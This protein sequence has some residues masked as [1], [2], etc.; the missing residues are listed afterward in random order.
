MKGT[1]GSKYTVQHTSIHALLQKLGLF[2]MENFGFECM[3]LQSMLPTIPLL[4]GDSAF[5]NVY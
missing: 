4:V 5:K 2:G 1:F 3:P